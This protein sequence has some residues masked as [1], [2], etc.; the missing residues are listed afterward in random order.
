MPKFYR[1]IQI[2]LKIE[3]FFFTPQWRTLTYFHMSG[4]IWLDLVDTHLHPSPIAFDT[5]V[6][7]IIMLVKLEFIF[8][9]T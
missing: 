4:G 6:L 5:N 7:Y 3:V 8:I 9:C 2:L 1:K